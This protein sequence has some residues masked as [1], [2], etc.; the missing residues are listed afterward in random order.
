MRGDRDERSNV[1]ATFMRNYSLIEICC[2][3]RVKLIEILSGDVLLKR[4]ICWDCD[5]VEGRG[6]G[7]RRLNWSA[8]GLIERLLENFEIQFVQV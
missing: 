6:Y 4:K 5:D 1:R 2:A 7:G 8:D 3:T